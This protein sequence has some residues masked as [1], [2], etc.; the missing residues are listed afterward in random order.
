MAN[1]VLYHEVAE[2][3]RSVLAKEQSVRKAVYGSEYKNH[4]SY[5]FRYLTDETRVWEHNAWDNVDWS[6]EMEQHA[7]QVVETQ[8]TQAVGDSKAKKLLDEPAKQWDAFYSQH[9]NNFFKDRN[10]L[11]KE[12]PELDMNNHP[13]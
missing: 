3:I 2:I 1:D 4:L 7:R 11:L 9:N 5:H 13:E 6:E 10:W 12:F 8:K